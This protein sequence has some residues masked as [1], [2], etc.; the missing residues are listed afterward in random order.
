MPAFQP[1]LPAAAASAHTDELIRR[2]D[3][4]RARRRAEAGLPRGLSGR[5]RIYV[6]AWSVSNLFAAVR[7]RSS[8]AIPPV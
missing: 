2:A 8:Q 1:Y 5:R 6:E 3:E 7:R 4:H